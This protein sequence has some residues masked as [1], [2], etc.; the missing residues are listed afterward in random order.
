MNIGLEDYSIS[1]SQ[2]KSI[3]NSDKWIETIK[4]ELQ[5]MTAN[6]FCLVKSIRCK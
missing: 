1:F 6:E 3:L 2:V 4:D 5:S